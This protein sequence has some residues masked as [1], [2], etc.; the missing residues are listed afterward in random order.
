[1]L[2]RNTSMR[3]VNRVLSGIKQTP[4]DDIPSAQASE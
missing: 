2:N 4:C 1:M 3:V